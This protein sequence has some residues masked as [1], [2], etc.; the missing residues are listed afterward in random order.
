MVTLGLPRHR[1]PQP[2]LLSDEDD[3]HGTFIEQDAT[4]T[5]QLVGR[6]VTIAGVQTI[7]FVAP[8]GEA[9]AE[10]MLFEHAAG[11]SWQT[12]A[13]AKVTGGPLTVT[14]AIVGPTPGAAG[15]SA[16][17]VFNGRPAAD[18]AGTLP[19]ASEMFGVYQPLAG[20]LGRQSVQRALGSDR[21][22]DVDSLSDLGALGQML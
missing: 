21:V 13:F 7:S 17:P 10:F 1:R 4:S 9:T 18:F 14:Q 3:P 19:Y 12:A 22:S 6:V 5:R 15:V 8:T 11:K 20:W 16:L 2:A